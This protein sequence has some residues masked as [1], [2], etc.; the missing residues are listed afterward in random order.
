MQLKHR[1]GQIPSQLQT[2]SNRFLRLDLRTSVPPH[3]GHITPRLLSV[4]RTYR[5]A[6]GNLE[7]TVLDMRFLAE[8]YGAT[9]SVSSSTATK[10][11]EAK[12]RCHLNFLT[13]TSSSTGSSFSGFVE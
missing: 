2:R 1:Y 8:R 3:S 13:A 7:W 12:D 5:E 10:Y 11:R 9:G 6:M 4:Y